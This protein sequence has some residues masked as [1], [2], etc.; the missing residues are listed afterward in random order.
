MKK[1]LIAAAVAASC[2]APQAFAQTNGASGFTGFSAA[3]NANASTSSTEVRNGS[4]YVDMG[5]SS[6]DVSLQAA[7]GFAMGNNY[8]LG[9]G[10]TYAL[11]D[12]KSGSVTV[13]DF[14][15]N[16]KGK[17]AYSLYLEP[18]YAIS[19]STLVYGKLAYLSMKGEAGGSIHG[20]EDFSGVG[21]GVGIRHKLNKNLFLQGEIAQAD[22]SHE[23][24]GGTMFKPSSTTGTVGI[25][26]QF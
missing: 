11:G 18:G 4:N 19:N 16:L 10:A 14:N 3:A 13:G 25:G 23:T 1:V 2:I 24:I 22:Y 6:Q 5:K 21:Y 7:Y 15:A 17:D 26:Y 12:L 8:V 9:L 20:S